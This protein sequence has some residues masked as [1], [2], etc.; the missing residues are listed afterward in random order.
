MLPT[1]GTIILYKVGAILCDLLSFKYLILKM[2]YKIELS[3]IKKK[4]EKKKTCK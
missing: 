3:Y 2:T 4:K 1:I